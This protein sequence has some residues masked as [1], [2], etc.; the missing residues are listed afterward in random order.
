MQD[1]GKIEAAADSS[2]HRSRGLRGGM[3]AAD[4]SNH[5]SRGL[6]G[7]MQSAKDRPV[8]HAAEDNYGR[9]D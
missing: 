5:R 8:S 7:G 3:Q 2:N 1:L 4:S 9:I 6:R